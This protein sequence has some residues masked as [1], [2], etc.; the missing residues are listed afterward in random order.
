MFLR[1][2]IDGAEIEKI[3]VRVKTVDFEDFGDESPARSSFDV[4][5]DVQGVTDVRLDR[6]IWQ[7]HAALQNAA[8]EPCQSLLR[9]T[10]VNCGQSAS[11]ARIQE[12]K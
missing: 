11:V 6:A 1:R 9:G 2:D 4:D 12:L 7:F 8:R 10:G 5:Y 3:G